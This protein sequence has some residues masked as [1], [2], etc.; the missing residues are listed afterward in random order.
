MSKALS[1]EK[2]TG[3]VAFAIRLI[4]ILLAILTVIPTGLSYAAGEEEKTEDPK[5]LM[6][7]S[8]VEFLNEKPTDI[9]EIRVS[10]LD[11][12][13]NAYDYEFPYSDSY[14]RSGSDKFS[15]WHARGSETN[16]CR[17]LEP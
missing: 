6:G 8:E 7:I 3:R 1:K 10:L 5:V 11:V 13:N 2:K 15:I 9:K 12:N 16:Q 4:A 17:Q 14:F